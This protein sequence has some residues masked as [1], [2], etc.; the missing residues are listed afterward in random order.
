MVDRLFW[1]LLNLNKS[2]KMF[3]CLIIIDVIPDDVWLQIFRYLDIHSLCNVY[4]SCKLFHQLLDGTT[5]GNLPEVAD[6]YLWKDVF[7]RD[8]STKNNGRKLNEIDWKSSYKQINIM[9][10]V[11]RGYHHS[12]LHQCGFSVDQ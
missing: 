11:T 7:E 5:A 1:K 8:W 10:I 12:I 6:Q 9:G 3:S 4:V 2:E